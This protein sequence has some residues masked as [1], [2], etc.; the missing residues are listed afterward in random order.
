MVRVKTISDLIRRVDGRDIVT[1]EGVEIDLTAEEADQ[2]VG[3]GAVLIVSFTED[4]AKAPI[5][6][7]EEKTPE[8]A[9]PK[10]GA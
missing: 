3:C 4:D 9:K 10:K 7:I 8:A 5:A 6:V 2:L 1:P